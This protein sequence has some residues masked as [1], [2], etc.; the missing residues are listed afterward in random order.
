MDKDRR[1]LTD[2]FSRQIQDPVT[3]VREAAG[4]GTTV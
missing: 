2:I 3:R 4:M 1:Q